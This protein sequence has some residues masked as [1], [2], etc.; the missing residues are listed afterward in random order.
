VSAVNA[1]GNSPVFFATTNATEVVVANLLPGTW[2]EFK[3][4]AKN[5]A[6][7]ARPASILTTIP[8]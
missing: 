3:V 8:D 4:V 2:Y 1:R 7:D 5:S 6:G